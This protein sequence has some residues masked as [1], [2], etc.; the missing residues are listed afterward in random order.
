[1]TSRPGSRETFDRVVL[2]HLD[3]LYQYALG[4]TRNRDEAKDVV[5]DT[6]LRAWTY[7]GSY[8]PGGDPKAWLYRILFHAF[9][10]GR[11]RTAGREL[12]LPDD[13]PGTDGLLY[14]RLVRDGGWKD[15]IETA[16]ASFGSLFGDEVHRAVLALPAVFRAPLL[17]CDV[18]GM[19]YARIAKILGCPVNTVR[20]RIA[21]GRRRLQR[22]L[23]TY[24]ARHHWFARRTH[25]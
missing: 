17:L 16:P 22:D 12:P 25:A 10:A 20:T 18:E 5:Q 13:A 24:A 14:E 15:P 7:Y 19:P 3:R 4:L 21:R 9:L 23:A 2:P 1:M 8:R 11:R 6:C